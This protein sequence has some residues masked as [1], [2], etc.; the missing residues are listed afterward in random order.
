MLTVCGV[1]EGNYWLSG[2]ELIYMKSRLDEGLLYRRTTLEKKEQCE[3]AKRSR[4]GG[5]ITQK[6]V[7]YF[8]RDF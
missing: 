7:N 5:V 2:E 8:C 3:K 4:L 6:M 1:V